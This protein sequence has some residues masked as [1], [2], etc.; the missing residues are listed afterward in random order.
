MANPIDQDIKSGNFKPVYLICG[1]EDFLRQSYKRRLRDAIVGKDT[2]NFNRFAG[3]EVDE[4]EIISLADTMPF[5]AAHRLILI[6]DSGFFKKAPAQ[7]TDYLDKM[8]D[9]TILLFVENK[10]D[11]KTKFYKKVRDLG[12]VVEM[13]RQKEGD[14]LIW[15]GACFKQY[16]LGITRATAE[17]FL[18]RTGGDMSNIR[19]EIDKLASYCAGQK[20]VRTEDVLAVTTVT[21]D[22]KI[23][24]LVDKIAAGNTP[25]AMRLY[26]EML[27]M[28][29]EPMYILA[30]VSRQFNQILGYKDMTA[31]GSDRSTIVQ[32]LRIPPFAIRKLAGEA[33]VYTREQILDKIRTCLDLEEAVKTGRLSD[34]LAAE[35]II[36]GGREGG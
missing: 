35:L 14:L 10:V 32:A 34:R 18:S 26:H 31:A 17:E 13:E 19:S 20:A 28:K 4:K 6:E 2:M 21:T 11:R 24:D 5:F 1:E 3:K 8:P 7:L 25:E 9:T 33:R 36:T 30:A 12:R 15:V 29:I 27:S 23:Y 16:G 22:T